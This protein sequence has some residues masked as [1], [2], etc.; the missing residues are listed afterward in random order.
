MGAAGQR[1]SSSQPVRTPVRIRRVCLY[2]PERTPLWKLHVLLPVRAFPECCRE[3][4]VESGRLPPW[5]P[6]GRKIEASFAGQA[7]DSSNSFK[8]NSGMLVTGP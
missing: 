6:Q 5:I 3:E 2:F 4:A 7:R 8:T 1:A